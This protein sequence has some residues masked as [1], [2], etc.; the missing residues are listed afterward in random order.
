[1]IETYRLETTQKSTE[2]ADLGSKPAVFQSERCNACGMRLDLPT[3]H[4]LCKHSFHQRCL[5]P[6]LD[7]GDGDMGDQLECAT[8]ASQNHMIR[9]IRRGQDEAADKHEYFKERLRSA[10]P[11]ERWSVVADFFGKGVMTTPMPG[12]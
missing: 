7:G 12:V 6:P 9:T 10:K 1:M 4:F 8:C 5:D 2:I 3:V 11:G